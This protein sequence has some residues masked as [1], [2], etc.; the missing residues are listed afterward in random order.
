MEGERVHSIG[1]LDDDEALELFL[2]RARVG[3]PDFDPGP[4]E[5]STVSDLCRRLDGLPLAIELVAPHVRVFG[6]D[7]LAERVIGGLALPAPNQRKERHRT[8]AAAIAWSHDLLDPVQQAVFR[9]LAVFVGGFD[10][11]AAEAVAGGVL[12]GPDVGL[13]LAD[14]VDQSLVLSRSTP[15]GHRYDM[16]QT[17]RAF[18]SGQLDAC[19]EAE[20]SVTDISNGSARTPAWL[21]TSP[22]SSIRQPRSTSRTGA[23]RWPGPRG[24]AM[25]SA[26][27]ASPWG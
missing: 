11:A 18:A 10:L 13:V 20:E 21:T 27:P 1:G 26:R 6:V 9:R 8:V 24:R 2:E 15:D 5:R 7:H 17:V 25:G 14:L 4:T 16:L 12:G 22:T 3:D 23:W 19:G